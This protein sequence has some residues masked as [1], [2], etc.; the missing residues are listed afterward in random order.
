[1]SSNT[2]EQRYKHELEEFFSNHGGSTS[3][4]IVLVILP[5]ICSI[6]LTATIVA[7]IGKRL[8][9][10][11]LII[12]EFVIIII[13]SVLSCTVLSD[14]LITITTTML[15]IIII[16]FL[17]I[18]NCKSR[19]ESKINYT[20]LLTKCRAFITNFRALTN[21]ITAICILAV[22]FKIFPRKFAKTE[23]Y[24]YS[25][26]DTGVGLFIISNALVA[27]ETQD[28]FIS[29]Q[30]VMNKQLSFI[31]IFSKNAKICMK[32][33]APL[34]ILGLG[35]FIAVELSDY[36]RHVTEYGVHWN[37]FIT[38]AFVKI[39]TSTI[40]SAINSKYSLLSGI[41][42]LSMH[43]YALSTNGLKEWVLGNSPRNDFVSANREGLVSVP[44]YVGLYFIGIALG[45]IINSTLYTNDSNVNNI[46]SQKIN[47]R[48][49][50][51]G[52][53]FGYKISFE[54]NKLMVLCIKLSLIAPHACGITLIC[55]YYFGISRRLANSGYCA[56]ILTLTTVFLTIVI[57]VEIMTDILIHMM[58]N[59]YGNDCDGVNNKSVKSSK[60]EMKNRSVKFCENSENDL[61]KLIRKSPIIFEAVNYNGLMFFLTC[62]LCTGIINMFIKTLYVEGYAALQIIILYISI[63]IIIAVIFHRYKLQ[64]KL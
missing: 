33:S 23:I 61:D 38:L 63:N 51:E 37:F 44:G 15:I 58:E 46:K 43:E 11:L 45:R 35:R 7:L 47:N 28:A 19:C 2:D 18:I 62:N 42:I 52:K 16:N 3:R 32:N 55:E 4:E 6:L 40:A 49:G 39:F 1:M 53:L 64:M 29:K 36:Q 54:Y 14:Y 50:I 59:N 10:N 31:R 13:P 20:E 27:P 8:H 25:L 17:I 41:W 57:L 9:Q 48:I 12:I 5:N 56:W 22:D 26:M 60:R 34:L 24:G 21:I 30:Y